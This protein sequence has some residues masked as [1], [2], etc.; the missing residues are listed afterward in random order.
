MVKNNNAMH[1]ILLKDKALKQ[2]T[3]L[4][5]K[6]NFVLKLMFICCL[7]SSIA[8]LVTVIKNHCFSL[9]NV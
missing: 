2:C 7:N 1:A 4:R 8:F 5:K 3:E 9:K 6:V